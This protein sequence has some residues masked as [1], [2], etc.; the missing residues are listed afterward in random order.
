MRY[1]IRKIIRI[2]A[3]WIVFLVLIVSDLFLLKAFNSEQ[4][5]AESVSE[6]ES[7]LYLDKLWY[8]IMYL[9][10]LRHTPQAPDFSRG[11][12]DWHRA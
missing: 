9:K 5:A 12:V 4:A 11:V 2:K 10:Y 6:G 7:L 8:V 1:K 3:V